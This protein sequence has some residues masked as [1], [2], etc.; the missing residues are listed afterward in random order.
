LR[1]TCVESRARRASTVGRALTSSAA[2]AL[3]HHSV[4]APQSREPER[5]LRQPV[6]S[7]GRLTNSVCGFV[8]S[9]CLVRA[10]E[11][12]TPGPVD[13]L[14]KGCGYAGSPP[15]SAR[16]TSGFCKRPHR[17]LP[18]Q[19]VAHLKSSCLFRTHSELRGGATLPA[20]FASTRACRKS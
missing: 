3:D 15:R 19:V 4:S 14:R 20:S 9:K 5:R 17:M 12:R 10:G 1:A 11:S 13:M 2:H 6:H 7:G 18:I 8:R 16:W